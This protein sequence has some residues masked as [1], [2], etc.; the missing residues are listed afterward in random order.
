MSG[1]N[2]IADTNV[3]IYILEGNHIVKNY[4]DAI[5]AATALHLNYPLLTADK[6]FS[7]IPDLPIILIEQ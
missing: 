4:L 7:D 6:D 3:L 1:I 2:L 5:I